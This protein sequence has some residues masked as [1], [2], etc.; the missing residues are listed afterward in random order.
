MHSSGAS[1]S[2]ALVVEPTK[3]WTRWSGILP[4]SLIVFLAGADQGAGNGPTP[5]MGTLSLSSASVQPQLRLKQQDL[6]LATGTGTQEKNLV[7]E[8]IV[9]VRDLVIY[10]EYRAS[11]G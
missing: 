3:L 10:H 6:R 1:V 2:L 4:G 7:S 8:Y 11:F 9:Y 5:C